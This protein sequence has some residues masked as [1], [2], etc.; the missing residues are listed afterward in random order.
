M[1]LQRPITKNWSSFRTTGLHRRRPFSQ[2]GELLRLQTTNFSDRSLKKRL[3]IPEF[4]D[5]ACNVCI[6]WRSLRCPAQGAQS[7]FHRT[8][9]IFDFSLGRHSASNL[10]GAAILPES[11]LTA[12]GGTA[13]RLKL[14]VLTERSQ[15][16]SGAVVSV[17]VTGQ[18]CKNCSNTHTPTLTQ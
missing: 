18:A 16:R 9:C 11:R 7:I 17:N 2:F 14:H 4:P 1:L 12:L 8:D 6:A 10:K 5:C 3:G 15:M 13:V